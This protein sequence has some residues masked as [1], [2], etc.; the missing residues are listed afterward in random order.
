MFTGDP[1]PSKGPDNR[2][3]RALVTQG[4]RKVNLIWEFTQAAI[5]LILVIGTVAAALRVSFYGKPG[6]EIPDILLVLVGTVV[7]A[8]FQRTNHMNIGGTGRKETEGETYVGR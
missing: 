3:E 8:Y 1:D 7:G 2:I 4:Q 6:D 5:A